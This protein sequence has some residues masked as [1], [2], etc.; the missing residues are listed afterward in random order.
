LAARALAF[1]AEDAPRMAR[2]LTL[3]G[4]SLSELIRNAHA[5]ELLAAVLEHLAGDESL[6]LT[7][8]ASAHV[9]PASILPAAVLLRAQAERS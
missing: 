4:S 3:S 2:F 1:L 6:L 9:D 8:A 5:P 7:F